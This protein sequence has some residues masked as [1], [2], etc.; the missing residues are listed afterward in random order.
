MRDLN[1]KRLDLF[2]Q[3]EEIVMKK[4][5]LRELMSSNKEEDLCVDVGSMDRE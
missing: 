3:K 1:Q 2:E 5:L 4:V